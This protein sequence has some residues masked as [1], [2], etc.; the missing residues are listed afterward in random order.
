MDVARYGDW[1]T[2]AYTNPKVQENYRR[3][4]SIKFPNEELTA[5]RPYKTTPI[6]DRLLALGA[7]MGDSWGLEVPLWFAPEGVRDVFSWRRSTDFE[8]VKAEVRPSARASA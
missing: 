4:F 1:A 2:L 7:Q 8:H 3:R 5:A 6:Y